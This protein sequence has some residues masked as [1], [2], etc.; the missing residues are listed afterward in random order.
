MNVCLGSRT[1]PQ[2]IVPSRCMS[3]NT[4]L[5]DIAGCFPK[6][7][8]KDN[9]RPCLDLVFWPARLGC[10]MIAIEFLLKRLSVLATK[11]KKKSHCVAE[12]TPQAGKFK[13]KITARE[14]SLE[15]PG[16]SSKT[17]STQVKTWGITVESPS[18]LRPQ[19]TCKLDSM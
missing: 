9:T 5:N 17:L 8:Q 15:H 3:T 6:T 11:D 7:H 4:L 2:Y 19:K 16:M 12:I 10:M 18:M 1:Q 14:S 13:N